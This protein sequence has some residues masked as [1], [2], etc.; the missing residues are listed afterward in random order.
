M[1]PKVSFP[2]HRL[3]SYLKGLVDSRARADG[4]LQR[5][6]PAVAAA[7][8]ALARAAARL[9]K[10]E[11]S[12]DRARV[13]RD[14]CDVLL[15]SWSDA[16][17]TDEIVPVHAWKGRY[18]KRGAFKQQIIS[19]LGAAGPSG[20]GTGPLA[21]QLTAFFGL[22]FL[23]LGAHSSWVSAS[24]VVKLKRL[25]AKGLVERFVPNDGGPKWMRWR[26][27]QPATASFDSLLQ[28]AAGAGLAIDSGTDQPEAKT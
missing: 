8:E 15:R 17:E 1:N 12:L 20:I 3:P 19:F 18:G 25:A 13:A 22:S 21:D 9:R 4:H 24:L 16:I 26:L 10:Q 14:A 27:P 11:A 28:Q 23:T 2:A 7:R 5:L 6:A